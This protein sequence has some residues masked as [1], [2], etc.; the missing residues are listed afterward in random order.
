[1]TVRDEMSQ[2]D[3]PAPSQWALW[4]ERLA[5]IARWHPP[6]EV[7]LLSTAVFVGV[8]TGYGAVVFIWLIQQITNLRLTFEQQMGVVGLIAFM[9]IAGVIVGVMVSRWASEAK[10][11]GVPEVM[12]AVAV[13]GGRIRPRV[14]L[15]KI[16]ASGL[17]IGAGGSAGREGPIVQVGAALGSTV[18]QFLRFS[19]DRVQTL[20]AAG[21]AA[22]IAATFNAPIAGSIFALEVILGR[23]S[24]RN[25]G[26]VVISAVSAS[27]ISRIYLGDQPAFAVPAYPLHHL[28]ELP[29]YVVLGLLAAVLAVIFI[30]VLYAL[31]DF[32]DNWSVP[33]PIKTALGM[34]LTG[35]VALLLPGR[36]VLGPGLH[37]IGELIAENIPLTLQMMAVLLLL[38]LAATSF[39]LGSGN[40]GGVFAPSLFMGAVLGG[41]VGQVAH[42]IWPDVAVNPGAYAI[43]GMAATFAGAARAPITAV[44]IVFEMS[45]DYKLILPLMLATVIA[46][47]FAEALFKES[48]YTLKLKR[49]GITIQAGRDVDVLQAVTVGEVMSRDFGAVS[50]N[51][52]LTELSDFFARTHRHGALV[53]DDK[54]K[55]WG[56]VTVSDLDRA[57]EEGLPR[58][59][60][61]TEIGTP[62][63]RLV[64]AF[65]DETLAEVL[66]RMGI[67]GYG[68]LPV[69]AR[70]DPTHVLGVIRREEVIRAYNMALARRA[71]LQHRAKRAQ[72]RNI[73]GT[74]FVDITLNE[75]DAAVGKRL[76]EIAPLLPQDSIIISVR[77]DGRMLIPHGQTVFQAGDSIT[78]FVRTSDIEQLFNALKSG[79]ETA[80]QS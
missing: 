67:R 25:F 33:M 42:A 28:G 10:G 26:A 71:E 80:Q 29:I 64:V 49:K 59:T 38:K 36:E 22:G 57:V 30:R 47:F 23:F 53:L 76:V 14:A 20:V 78:A 69:V 6:E 52:T 56:L 48:I 44:L 41:I 75:G 2:A 68:R 8:G 39:T 7:V 32:F 24:A 58:S 79:A 77:R 9:A 3:V 74:E 13:R 65:P 5:A 12:E 55:L 54:G 27:I 18:G 21:S 34:V 62:R 61:V 35:A 60:H 50:T 11:H 70:E 1:M 31:E 43:V 40:S 46:T 66:T 63:A 73:D 15:V 72:L 37:M 16:L 17:T 45:N 51:T 4:V 19:N